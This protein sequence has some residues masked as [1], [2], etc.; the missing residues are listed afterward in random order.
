MAEWTRSIETSATFEQSENLV[1]R[2]QAGEEAAFREV[3]VLYKDMV[4]TLACKLLADKGE[5]MDVTQEVFLNLFRKIKAFRGECSLKTW[6]YRVA[7]NQASNRN[8]W[9]RRRS[10]SRTVSIHLDVRRDIREVASGGPSPVRKLYSR[11]I[12]EALRHGLNRLP[13]DQR[14]VIVLR[15]VEGLTY[16]EIAQVTGIKLGTV[17]SRIARAREQ[18]RDYLRDFRGSVGL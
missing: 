6:L 9:W 2:L 17:K 4:Y 5:A 11:E 16:E 1:L 3:F 10:R 7:V 14:T 8:R 13:F 18:L 15:D 12:R